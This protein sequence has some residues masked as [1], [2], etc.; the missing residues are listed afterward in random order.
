M[1]I[2]PN[3]GN[4]D[5]TSNWLQSSSD[6]NPDLDQ[7]MLNELA[8]LTQNCTVIYYVHFGLNDNDMDE[9]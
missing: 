1:S 2:A 3:R 4:I 7:F 5:P 9:G 8:S 6:S